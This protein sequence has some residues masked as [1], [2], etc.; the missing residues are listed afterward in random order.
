MKIFTRI[1]FLGLL[2]MF[3]FSLFSQTTYYVRESGNDNNDGLSQETAFAT[4][5]KAVAK[6]FG[7]ADSGDVVMVIGNVLNSPDS[8]DIDGTM[9][10][11]TDGYTVNKILTLK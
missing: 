10:Y 7:V 11:F 8:L 9:E 2:T 1:L 3:S 4:L 6:D 5:F